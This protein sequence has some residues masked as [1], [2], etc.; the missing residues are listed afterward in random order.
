MWGIKV[1]NQKSIK[2]LFVDNEENNFQHFSQNLQKDTKFKHT[3]EYAPTIIDAYRQALKDT[4]DILIIRFRLRKDKKNGMNLV[5]SLRDAGC[6]TPAIILTD[7][8]SEKLCLED[9]NKSSISR[10]IPQNTENPDLLISIIADTVLHFQ[11][12]Q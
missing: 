2:M 5:Y 9:C 8:D 6:H 3:M 1:A 4:Y 12:E 11:K 10:C 7:D